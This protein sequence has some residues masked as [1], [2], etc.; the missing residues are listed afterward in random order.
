MHCPPC[1]MYAACQ[2]FNLRLKRS[3]FDDATG[4]L[5]PSG[6]LNGN[7]HLHRLDVRFLSYVIKSK[8]HMD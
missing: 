1:L 7:L 3:F 6:I 4:L 5:L 2:M 8:H